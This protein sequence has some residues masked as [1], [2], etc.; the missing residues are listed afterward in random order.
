M[1]VNTRW[2]KYHNWQDYGQLISCWHLEGFIHHPSFADP[3]FRLL[4]LFPIVPAL[5]PCALAS[6]LWL[7]VTI[8]APSRIYWMWGGYGWKPSSSSD[9]SIRA[10]PVYP[11]IENRHSS[12][13]S[14]SRQVERFEA[15]VSQSAV[16]SPPLI[17]SLWL[18]VIA[19]APSRIQDKARARIR[20]PL[21]PQSS[22]LTRRI[23]EVRH[24]FNVATGSVCASFSFSNI[25]RLCVGVFYALTCRIWKIRYL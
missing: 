16:P 21:R 20:F 18:S 5:V 1:L 15:A 22:T 19:F 23:S 12:L 3:L 14:N 25:L 4:L 13:S 9:F 6:V 10:F 17:S 2:C 11:L 24:L 7:S 8:L